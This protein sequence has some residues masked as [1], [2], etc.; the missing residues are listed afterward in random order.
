MNFESGKQPC[1]NFT[2]EESQWGG[3]NVH[4]CRM[5]PTKESTVSF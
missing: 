4:E 5:C 2:Y 1:D 3:P